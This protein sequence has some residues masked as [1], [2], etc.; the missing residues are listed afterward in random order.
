M[1]QGYGSRF[2]L[3]SCSTLP[4]GRLVGADTNLKGV[5]WVRGGVKC[6]SRLVCRGH[7]SDD[8]TDRSVTAVSGVLV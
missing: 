1:G 6:L 8:S 3:R 2:G 5:S 7:R 4:S